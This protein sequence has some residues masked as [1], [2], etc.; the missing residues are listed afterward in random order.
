LL[1]NSLVVALLGPAGGQ[2]KSWGTIESM[3][4]DMVD[5]LSTLTIAECQDIKNGIVIN[6]MRSA[7][8]LVCQSAREKAAWV[9]ALRGTAVHFQESEGGDEAGAGAAQ[10]HQQRTDWLYEVPEEMDVCIAQRNFQGAVVFATRARAEFEGSKALTGMVSLR[11]LID[12][13]VDKL[14]AVLCSE[15]SRPAIR[16]NAIRATVK[17]LLDLGKADLGHE[18]R[19]LGAL[20]LLH[21]AHTPLT[22]RPHTLQ[23]YLLNRT[24]RIKQKFRKVKM[25]GSTELYALKLSRTFFST[26][27][28]TCFEFAEFF[29]DSASSAFVSWASKELRRFATNFTHQVLQSLNKLHTVAQCVQKVMQQCSQLS[30]CGLDLNFVLWEMLQ[31]KTLEAINDAGQALLNTTSTDIDVEDWQAQEFSGNKYALKQLLEKMALH[32]FGIAVYIKDKRC[33]LFEVTTNCIGRVHEYVS[34]VLCLITLRLDDELLP[35]LVE[36]FSTMVKYLT[37]K[38]HGKAIFEK[39]MEALVT[40]LQQS[41]ARIEVVTGRECDILVGL[42]GD[43]KLTWDHAEGSLI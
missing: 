19:S 29:D 40:L 42:E 6:G 34:A 20:L 31:P 5:P 28:S 39:N 17:F 21:G 36:V 9:A 10:G 14:T 11:R 2:P 22:K 41:R 1:N 25:E 37:R 35:W 18:V 8:I 27:R 24:Q 3:S 30:D 23:V 13:K 12:E 7:Q 26:L 15:L 4:L 38:G 33:D 16:T 32:D 43:I